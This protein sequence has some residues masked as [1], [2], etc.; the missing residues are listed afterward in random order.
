MKKIIIAILVVIAL[1]LMFKGKRISGIEETKSQKSKSEAFTIKVSG[2]EN[3]K[4]IDPKFAYCV[5]KDGNGENIRPEISWKNAPEGIKSFAIIVVDPDVPTDFTDA[6]KEDKIIPADQK[7]QDF[8]HYA[9]IDIPANTN[10]I[11]AGTGRGSKKTKESVGI[12]GVNDYA[13]FMP[14]AKPEDYIGWDGMCPPWN[15][16]RIHH[17]NFIVYAFKT[18][19]IGLKD[20]FKASEA[21]N[22]AK[23]NA[24][25]EARI[26]G[27]YTRNDKIK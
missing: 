16:E 3:D 4:P 27:T 5:G 18:K 22:L 8:V 19:T 17:Y 21:Y 13:V 24:V 25:V 14:D 2:I 11:E 15:D 7:R 12:A 20:N 6:G 9:L 10:K 26:I 1:V 23:E